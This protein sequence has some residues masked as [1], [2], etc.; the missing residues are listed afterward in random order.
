MRRIALF[1]LLGMASSSQVYATA[2]EPEILIYRGETNQ[3]YSTP[4][5]SYFT[6]NNP[7]PVVW[8]QAQKAI[9]NS[10]CW[11]RYIGTWAI[12]DEMLFLDA[13]QFPGCPPVSVV[14]NGRTNTYLSPL[15]LLLP[16]KDLPF[17]ADW[18][19]GVLRLPEGRELQYVHMGFGSIYERDHFIKLEKGKVVAEKTVDNLDNPRLY[20]SD[21]DLAW[22]EIGKMTEGGGLVTDDPFAAQPEQKDEGNW[23]DAR[24]I[25]TTNFLGVV[26]SEKPFTTRGILVRR[27]DDL[28]GD[29]FGLYIPPTPLTPFDHLPLVDIPAAPEIA[30]GSHVEIIARFKKTEHAHALHVIQIR[31]LKNNES[32]HRRDYRLPKRVPEDTAR[33]LADPQH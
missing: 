26:K 11:R 28:F 30:N 27:S 5:E 21:A 32:I 12:R 14:E 29:H 23:Y 2:Q 9:F 15:P 16:G 25:R 7:R 1:V 18:F 10:G 13:L 3:M 22:Q 6:T 31:E 17:K 20:T 33:K 8:K 24:M 4:L 19:N